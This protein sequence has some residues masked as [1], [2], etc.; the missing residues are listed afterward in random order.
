MLT[1]FQKDIVSKFD[2][3]IYFIKIIIWS[4]CPLR[5]TYCFVDKEENEV[6]SWENFK[7]NIDLLMFSKWDNKLLHILWWEPLIYIELIKKWVLYARNLEKETWKNLNISF[8]T[9]WI[10]FSEENLKFIDEYK[11]FL[12]WSIDWPKKI[13]DF[14]RIL[15]NGKWSY[16]EIISKKSL[17]LSNVKQKYL[18]IAMTATP[19]T[20][21]ELSNS[22]K[23]LVDIEWLD[24]SFN[25]APVE[26]FN[27]PK[28]KKKIFVSELSKVYEY[29]IENI[30]KWRFLYI[31]SFNKEFWLWMLNKLRYWWRCLFFYIDTLPNGNIT[32]NPFI[33]ESNYDKFIVTNIW[34]PTFFEDISKYLWCNFSVDS[35]KCNECRDEY[36]FLENWEDSSWQMTSYRDKISVYYANKIKLLSLNNDLF[37]EY[38]EKSKDQMY[39]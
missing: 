13:H 32:F 31:N 28:D 6:M 29:V 22:Y 1:T 39:V 20:V 25:I 38:I 3:E 36:N 18:W 9:S 30:A 21:E 5:C 26:W 16:D 7:R 8:C 12:A 10:Y 35:N 17:V 23:Y 24:C 2:K 15:A 4:A 27:W 14:K 37:K 33:N 11:I 34:S 19:D